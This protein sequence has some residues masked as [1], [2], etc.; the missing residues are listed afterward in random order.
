M[1]ISDLRLEHSDIDFAK[2]KLNPDPLKQ[3]ECWFQEACAEKIV[4][5]NAMSLATTSKA[6]EPSIRTVLLKIFDQ[7][8]FIF[9]TNYESEKAR[10]IEEN[11]HVAVLFP[12]ISPDRQVIIRGCAS[13]ISARASLKYFM[14]RP[15][16]SQLGAWVSQQSKA[17]SS[18]K[19]L[20]DAFAKVTKQFSDKKIP[21]PG[22]W[23]GYRIIPETYEFWQGRSN[24]LHDRFIYIC[25]KDASWRIER[26]SP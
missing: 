3:F 4:Q 12:W 21:L 2:D 25:Q 10:Q 9:F 7:D 8:G 13:K 5:P 19:I 22:F 1:D 16:G 20:E 14:S 26:L 18:R 24:R 11:P 17:I 6:G 23:G 15:R